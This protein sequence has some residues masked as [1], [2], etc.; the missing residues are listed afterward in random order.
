[1]EGARGWSYK[2][3]NLQW[4]HLLKMNLVIAGSVLVDRMFDL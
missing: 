4:L 2:S 1:M 3:H